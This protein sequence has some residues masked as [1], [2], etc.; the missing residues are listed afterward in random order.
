[1]PIIGV[2]TFIA[3]NIEE[4]LNKEIELSRCSDD[5]KNQQ[6]ARLHKFWEQN[7]PKSQEAL[8]R[9]RKVALSNGNIFEELL[10]TVQYCSLGQ[11]TSVLYEI[12]GKYRRNV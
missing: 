3:P 12:G 6:I 10:Y 9:L 7:K 1:M 11:I 4:Q 2:N 5:E 8:N